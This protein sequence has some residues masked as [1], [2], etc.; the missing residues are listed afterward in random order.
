MPGSAASISCT[1]A[2]LNTAVA[3]VLAAYAERLEGAADFDGALHELIQTTI[4]THRRILFN[5]DGY[6]DSWVAEAHRRGLSDLRTTPAALAHFLD[7]KNVALY[8]RQ[9]VYTAE[10]L[11]ARHAVKLENYRKTIRIEALTLLDMVRRDILP[12]VSRFAGDCARDAAALAPYAANTN[13][14]ASDTAACLAA[15]IGEAHAAAE[16]LAA[17][18]E[19]LDRL[20]DDESGAGYCADTLLPAM[21]ALRA[22]VDAMELR[23]PAHVWP[24]PSYGEMLFSVK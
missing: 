19:T 14:Y 22:P 17:D 6:D 8:A 13:D 15:L 12:A 4:R 5:G 24:Y 2:I 3:D 20:A 21:A 7:E 9:H 11:T 10:E 18:L 23:C 1:N 16:A